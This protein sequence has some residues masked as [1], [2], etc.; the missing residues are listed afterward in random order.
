LNLKIP[1]DLFRA[2]FFFTDIVGLSK[3]DLSTQTQAKKIKFL[4]KCIQECDTFKSTKN[5]KL[6]QS[7]GDGVLI[8]F[9]NGIDE[10]LKLAMEVHQK[11]RAYNQ[12]GNEFDRIDIRIGCNIGN[13]FVIRDFEGTLSMWGPGTIMAK[14][15]M[16]LGESQHILISAEMIESIKEITNDYDQFI[17]PIQDY[18]I[19]HQ[20][21]I[22]IYSIY[23]E[24][25]GNPKSPILE[26]GKKS[27]PA[28]EIYQLRQNISFLTIEFNL[29]L[30]NP[31]EY[32]LKIN[33][34]YSLQNNSEAPV[35]KIINGITTNVPKTMAELNVK[36]FDENQKEL[37]IENIQV[38]SP[39]RKEFTIKLNEPLK[40]DQRDRHYNIIYEVEE[41]K[42]IFEHVFLINSK[43]FTLSFTYPSEEKINSIK[44]YHI[45]TQDREKKLI[46]QDPNTKRGLFT[47]INWN[48]ENGVN[49]KDIIRLEW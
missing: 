20:D 31:K 9:L 25:F 23:G 5:E 32:F 42:P 43:K 2:S 11:L 6:I 29:K 36:I 24:N 1:K 34:I 37:D 12:N 26:M 49:E 46:P 45:S 28:N 3:S 15:V 35:Y 4:D 30:K 39:L 8:A 44:L 40:K 13:V 16:D 27:Y 18:T 41:P 14:R 21:K 38:A 33:R 17:H 22:L 10:P 7:T 19:K 48:L 47:Q